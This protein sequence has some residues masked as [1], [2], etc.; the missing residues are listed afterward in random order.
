MECNA[1]RGG[2]EISWANNFSQITRLTKRNERKHVDNESKGQS[3]TRAATEML[4][5]KK[6]TMKEGMAKVCSFNK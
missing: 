3:E 6:R 5:A 1:K 2:M 4:R